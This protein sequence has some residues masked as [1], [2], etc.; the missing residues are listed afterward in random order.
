LI[1]PLNFRYRLSAFSWSKS[2]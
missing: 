2:R 1:E